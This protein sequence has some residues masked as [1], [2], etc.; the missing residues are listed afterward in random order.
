[1]ADPL[2]IANCSGFYGDRLSA[3]RE[4]GDGGPIDVLS[5]DWL[6]ELAMLILAKNRARDAS[7]GFAR[8]FVAQMEQ[9]MGDCL[10]RGIKVVSNAGG[11]A[12][13]ACAEAV[14]AVADKLGLSPSI[15][16]IEG[17]DLLDRLADL[18]AAGQALAN[19]DTGAP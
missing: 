8:T 9:V 6:A 13:A 3:A 17:D 4:M 16:F 15:A 18:R 19:L 5:G 12:P 14:H 7:T 11:L 1:M 10:D 2:R